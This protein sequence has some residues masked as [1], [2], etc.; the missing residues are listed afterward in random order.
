MKTLNL[1]GLGCCVGALLGGINASAATVNLGGA[2]C[3]A[4]LAFLSCVAQEVESD[5]RSKVKCDGEALDEDCAAAANKCL[6]KYPVLAPYSEMIAGAAWRYVVSYVF[7][8]TCSGGLSG[9][10]LVQENRAI[11]AGWADL[12]VDV[13]YCSCAQGYFI[14]PRGLTPMVWAKNSECRQCP[15]GGTT[16]VPN[17]IDIASCNLP[18]GEFSDE[19]GS[20]I[21]SADCSASYDSE[22]EED[23]AWQ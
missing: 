4:C 11:A 13:G 14:Q 2:D 17:T 10:A 6:A 1:I 15:A 22:A 8:T 16:M 19:K 7:D 21:L 23:A 12:C 3:D 5:I 20:G 9:D 18:A